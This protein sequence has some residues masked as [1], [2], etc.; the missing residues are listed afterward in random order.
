MRVATSPAS[1]GSSRCVTPRAGRALRTYGD[2]EADVSERSAILALAARYGGAMLAFQTP[3]LAKELHLCF[4]LLV[5]PPD[6]ADLAP[7]NLFNGAGA[8]GAAG[9]GAEERLLRSSAD[10]RFFAASVLDCVRSIVCELYSREVLELLDAQLRMDAVAAA[11]APRLIA[12][13]AAL[14]PEHAAPA[15]VA[16]SP[17]GI[18]RSRGH[19]CGGSRGVLD[20]SVASDVRKAS[21]SSPFRVRSAAEADA[22]HIS[23][24]SSPS[25]SDEGGLSSG[26]GG[27]TTT[28][29]RRRSGRSAAVAR[30]DPSRDSRHL[31]RGAGLVLYHKQEKTRDAFLAHLRTQLDAEASLHPGGGYRDGACRVRT[32]SFA[33]CRRCLAE[34]GPTSRW[35][36]ATFFVGTMV[37]VCVE[38]PFEPI[39]LSGEEGEDGAAVATLVARTGPRGGAQRG[40]GARK[41]GGKVRLFYF[42]GTST[43]CANPPHNLTRSP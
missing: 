37:R 42:Y 41:G 27:V 1:P 26:R 32:E 43:I 5:L 7:R 29:A 11:A 16:S 31:Y 22:A 23:A 30:F 8:E 34:V 6:A 13:L 12:C 4:R 36:F 40:G 28:S 33:A 35:W 18:A 19:N 9:G 25:S 10:A 24:L 38:Q 39:R 21:P 2:T 17:S 15:K 14:L 20:G 3:N